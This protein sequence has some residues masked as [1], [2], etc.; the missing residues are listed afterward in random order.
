MP[1]VSIEL[2]YEALGSETGIVIATNDAGR[3]RQ[4]LYALRA[5]SGDP[6]LACLS[7]V[8]SPT[9]PNELWIGKFKE[10]K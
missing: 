1:G 7:I 2:L 9:S 5:A 6:D 8:Q 10:R 3:C 4:K